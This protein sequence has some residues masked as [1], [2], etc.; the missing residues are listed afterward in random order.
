MK[1]LLFLATLLAWLAYQTHTGEIHYEPG[2][3][4]PSA[5]VQV[6]MQDARAIVHGEFRITPL[7]RFRAEARV[8]AHERYWLGRSARLAPVDLALGWGA[9]SD[10]TN[11]KE[12]EISQT[13][14]FYFWRSS[15]MPL[16]QRAITEQSANMHMIPANDAVRNILEHG[17]RTGDIVRFSG[18]LVSIDT[19]DGWRWRSS[20]SRNDLGDGACELVWVEQLSVL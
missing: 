16:T 12:I 3:M 6:R 13:G 1:W 19:E 9:M 8:L 14:R 4:A 20:M 7:A 10:E 18:Y 11:L 15:S 5:P 2:M 17:I